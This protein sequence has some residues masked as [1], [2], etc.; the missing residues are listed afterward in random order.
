MG[1]DGVRLDGRSRPVVKRRH[2]E[3]RPRRRMTMTNV[4]LLLLEAHERAGKPAGRSW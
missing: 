3:V 1:S 4:L 2:S